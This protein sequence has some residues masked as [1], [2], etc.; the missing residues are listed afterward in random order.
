MNGFDKGL[1]DGQQRNTICVDDVATSEE[2]NHIFITLEMGMKHII[3]EEYMTDEQ[4]IRAGDDSCNDKPN[5]IRFNVEDEIKKDFIFKFGIEFCL[6]KQLMSGI[7]EHNI[8]NGRELRFKKND[9]VRCRF[10]CKYKKH[11][12]Y[13]ILCIRVLTYTTF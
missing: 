13:I 10:V 11:Y 2:V 5:V 1:D 3:E 12:D 6:L 8:L 9:A 7:L 4:E